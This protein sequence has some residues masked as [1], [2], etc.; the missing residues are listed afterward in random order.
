M[1]LLARS[2]TSKPMTSSAEKFEILSAYLDNEASEENRT[3]VERWIECD[4]S[5]R[6]QYQAQL[7]IK[8][9]IR[10]LPA[11]IFSF[12][13]TGEAA[14][15]TCSEKRGSATEKGAYSEL[16][17]LK[18]DCSKQNVLGQNVLE[19]NA[20]EQALDSQ[21]LEQFSARTALFPNR[22]LAVT[23][24]TTASAYRWKDLLLIA[25]AISA[26]AFTALSC[27]SMKRSQ[28]GQI[29]RAPGR[30]TKVDT[31]SWQENSRAIFSAQ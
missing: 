1:V 9:A 11:Q 7:Q 10:S 8:A 15:G 31:F 16:N 14:S 22:R 19:Q 21:N 24:S 6:Q 5:F 20:L 18:Q 26:T 13:L 29:R 23:S 4:P 27:S 3:L 17:H 25:T 2:Y 12:D 28:R 30:I